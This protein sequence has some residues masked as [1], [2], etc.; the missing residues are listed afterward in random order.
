MENFDIQEQ[1]KLIQLFG[2]FGLWG[3]VLIILGTILLAIYKKRKGGNYKLVIILGVGLFFL[4]GLISGFVAVYLI[5]P[6]YNL[7][8]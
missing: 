2:H 3:Y 4:Y 6:I 7:G 1:L 8:N 5:S